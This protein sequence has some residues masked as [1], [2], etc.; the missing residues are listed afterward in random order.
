[1]IFALQRCAFCRNCLF[2]NKH[3]FA[4]WPIQSQ[5]PRSKEIFFFFMVRSCLVMRVSHVGKHH[6]TTRDGHHYARANCFQLVP[7]VC[8]NPLYV[9]TFHQNS[10]LL[11][12]AIRFGE[13]DHP[14]PS[15]KNTCLLNVVVANPT[16]VANKKDTFEKLFQQENIQILCLAETSATK[17]VQKTCQR[18]LNPLQLKCFWSQPVPPQRTCINGE[19]SIR[20]RAGGCNFFCNRYEVL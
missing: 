18:S 15:K 20:G 3:P 6:M 16:S 14:G 4:S 8:N 5:S 13:A 2:R 10:P 11:G 12:H 19:D 1:M 7:F 17:E 9:Q